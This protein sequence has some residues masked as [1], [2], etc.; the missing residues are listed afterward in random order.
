VSVS[1]FLGLQV[2]LR[3]VLAQQRAL[4]VTAHNVANANTVGYSRQEAV[5]STSQAFPIPGQGQVG[6]GVDV[7]TYRRV[8]D[9]FVDVQ[10]RAQT[11]RKGYHDAVDDGLEQ[12]ELALR[13]PSDTGLSALLTR[14]WSSWQDVVNAPENVATR[15]AL[16]QNAASLADGFRTL[17]SQLQTYSTQADQNITL[18]LADLSAAGAQIADLN[19]S[20]V[21]DKLLSGGAPND[22]LDDRDALLD[23]LS[24]LA[25]VTWTENADGSIDVAAGGFALVTGQSSATAAALT[26]LTGLTSGKL[27]GLR[28]LRDTMLPGYRAELDAVAAALVTQTNAQHAAGYDLAGAAGGAF[29]TGADASDIAVSAALLANPTLVA[30]AGSPAPGDTA[31]ARAIA[32]LADVPLVAGATIDGAYS[33]LVTKI[34]S[35]AREARRSLDGATVLADALLSRRDSISGVSL[36]EEMANLIRFQRGFQASSRALTAMDEL[37]DVLVNRMGRVGL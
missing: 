6:T 8:R 34:G 36:D 17:V 4:D 10:L 26:D 23:R 3:G 12:V 32:A 22:L 33:Q 14:Y 9:S 11:M 25:N 27:A 35:D 13:E 37:I 30:A 5:L 2:A 15:Q 29:F 7:D 28:D 24:E 1:T 21:R 18:T 31:N 20:I 19:A 16:V